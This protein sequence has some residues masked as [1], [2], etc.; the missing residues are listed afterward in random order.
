M[1]KSCTPCPVDVF[2]LYKK[3]APTVVT[4]DHPDRNPRCKSKCPSVDVFT[5][6]RKQQKTVVV[7]SCPVSRFS[8]KP[9]VDV[10]P[11]VRGNC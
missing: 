10:F 2:P 8:W 5:L 9:T 4:Y 11:L 1:T 3:S 6:V 7:N